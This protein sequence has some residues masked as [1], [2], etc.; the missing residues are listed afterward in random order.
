MK[1]GLIFGAIAVA[2]GA[3]YLIKRYR[4]GKTI[5]S[6]GSSMQKHNRHSTDVFSRAK[7]VNT[8]YSA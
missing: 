2:A 4:N 1:K 3:T 6:N 7:T 8:P 5:N